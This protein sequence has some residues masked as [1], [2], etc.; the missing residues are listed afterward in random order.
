MPIVVSKGES[1]E[2]LD[3]KYI[4]MKNLVIAQEYSETNLVRP[5][6]SLKI[7]YRLFA[8]DSSGNRHYENKVRQISIEDYL[9]LALTKASNGDADL[10][11]AMGAIEIALANII[12]DQGDVGETGVV[13]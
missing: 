6:Y 12:E 9:D 11:N 13:V 2:A 7:T 1:T 5:V 8:V 3:Y 10:I 4:F